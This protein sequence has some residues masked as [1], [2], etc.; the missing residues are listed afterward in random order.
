MSEESEG[1]MAG[2]HDGMEG[3][4]ATWYDQGKE[5]AEGEGFDLGVAYAINAT[6]D[7]LVSMGF[8]LVKQC[9]F[10]AT[11]ELIPDRD[12]SHDDLMEYI[13]NETKITKA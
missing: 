7:H 1:W 2:Y 11:D 4:T 12:K 5:D 10:E 6:I 9:I 13:K 3:S 8:V